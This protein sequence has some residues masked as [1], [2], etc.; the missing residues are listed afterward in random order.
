MFRSLCLAAL[1][2]SPVVTDTDPIKDDIGGIYLVETEIRDPETEGVSLH[3]GAAVIR[4]AGD[5]FTVEICG[6]GSTQG[7]G[8]LVGDTFS[9]AWRQGGSVGLTVYQRRKGGVL[10]GEWCSLPGDGKTHEEK[11]TLLRTLPAKKKEGAE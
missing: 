10:V 3:R 2:L 6:V 11:L 9:V 1:F 7:V 4:K 8:R 5:C